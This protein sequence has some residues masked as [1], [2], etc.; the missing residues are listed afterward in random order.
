MSCLKN[1]TY[2]HCIP[3]L[4]PR[5]VSCH[6]PWAGGVNGG[7]GSASLAPS[8][9]MCAAKNGN[10]IL[11]WC[12]WLLSKGRMFKGMLIRM[13]WAMV[14]MYISKGGSKLTRFDHRA[15]KDRGSATGKI[16]WGPAK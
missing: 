4:P 11:I 15:S 7:N 8:A 10:R 2:M 12:M 9:A 14:N 5:K 16:F 13:K 1:H 3:N 6:E